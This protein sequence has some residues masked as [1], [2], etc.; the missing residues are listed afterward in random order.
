MLLPN[1]S[2]DDSFQKIQ[3][4]SK[5]PLSLSISSIPQFPLKNAYSNVI[6]PL[7]W[8][9]LFPRVPPGA[10]REHTKTRERRE[11]VANVWVSLPSLSCLSVD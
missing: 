4:Y 5:I 11:N 10:A 3:E 8:C 6:S 7:F 2:L 1:F 9:I